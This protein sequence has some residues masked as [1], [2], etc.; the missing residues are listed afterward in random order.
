MKKFISLLLLSSLLGGCTSVDNRQAS[1]KNNKGSE[2]KTAGKPDK[3]DAKAG[4]AS[5]PAEPTISEAEM[6]YVKAL[7]EPN[8]IKRNEL[9]KAARKALLAEAE[10]NKNYKAHLLLGYMADLGQ[11]MKSDG[12][13]AAQHYRAAAD[14]GMVEAKIAL[15]EFWRRNDIFLDEA[16]KQIRSIPNYEDNPAAL[17]VLG[18]IYYSMFENDKGF[19]ILKKAYFSKHRT[20]A[21]RLEVLKILHNAF[22]KYFR[23]NNYDAALKEL[24]RADE[25]E[26]GNYLTP[27]LIGLVEIRRGNLAEAEKQFNLSWQRNPAVPETYRELA[28]LKART[29][30]EAEAMED[31]RTAYA[32]SGRKPEFQRAFME[33]CVSESNETLSSAEHP[34]KALV[35]IDVTPLAEMLPKLGHCLK[36]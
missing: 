26:S 28:F 6:M 14:S 18:S 8:K 11:G 1:E 4:K 3:P 15:A 31:I 12:I 20:P 32:V 5:A 16:V 34:S 25:L 22:E 19:Q 29:G 21:T 24:K 27:Y 23:G 36:Q 9:F 7:R 10:Q 2:L 17:C 35:P 30:R 13:Q 33:I